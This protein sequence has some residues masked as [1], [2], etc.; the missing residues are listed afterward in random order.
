MKDHPI[1]R[2]PLIL[3]KWF[4]RPS[5]HADIEGDLIQTFNRNVG[6]VGRR[7]AYWKLL[8]DVVR[9]FR[10]GIIRPLKINN[11]KN[12]QPMLRHNILLSFRNFMRYKTSFF[13]NI[14]GL[15][16]GLACVLLIFLWVTDEMAMDQFHKNRER[17]YQV[18]ENVQQSGGVITRQTTSGPTAALVT[19][20]IPEVESAIM[21]TA[22]WGM[23]N[24]ISIDE[25]DI[26][27]TCLY[28][29]E[30]FFRMFSFPLLTGKPGEVLRDKSS[31]V[32]SDWVAINLF[33]SIEGAVGKTVTFDHKKELQVSGVV[34][35]PSNSSL[36]FDYVINFEAFRDE[37]DWVNSWGSTAPRTY[38][39]IKPGSDPAIVGEK[40]ADVVRAK[41]GTQVTHRAQFLRKFT[42]AYLHDRYENGKLVG[43]RVEY[44][45]LFSIIAVFILVIACMNFMNL[46]T[47]RASRRVKEV[48]IKK[49]IGARQWSL[50]GQFLS[51]SILLSLMSLAI[52]TVIVVL[53]L[54]QF[55]LLTGKNLTLDLSS[56][57][58]WFLPIV[59]LATGVLAGSYP[60]WYLSAFR[61]ALV[62]KGKLAGS[63]GE[64]FARK[65]LVAFQFTASII[66]IVCVVVVYKQIEFVQTKDIGYKK[67]NVLMFDREGALW[68]KEKVF[69][70]ELKKLPGIVAAAQTGHDMTGHNGGTS[71]V[72]WPGKDPENRTE[73]ERIHCS[74]GLIELLGLTIAEGRSFTDN[75][76]AEKKN[77]V[78][79]EAAIKFMGITDPIGKQVGFGDETRTIIGVVRDFNFESL[80]EPVKP[81][82]INYKPEWAGMFML[83][84]E[85][86]K[87]QETVA[88]IESLY[89]SFNPGYPF[90]FRF[91]DDDYQTMYVAESR[92]ARLSR[93]FAGLAIVIS[94]LGLFG[95][96][97]FTA[98]RR[99][100]EISIR[101]VLGAG[102][103]R[104]VLLLSEEFSKIMII[105]LALAIPIS[106]FI[107]DRWLQG[108]TFRIELEWWFFAVPGVAALLIAWLS[109]SYQTIKA[110]RVNP[111]ENLKTE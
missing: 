67:D 72:T 7:Q 37:N 79:N 55:N 28:A 65:G 61:P 62:L 102:S 39:L 89:H 97:A 12:Y 82:F 42:D 13:I 70:D 8:G 88:A 69:I 110:A 99:M 50:V 3:F 20:E 27:G 40:I 36:S 80:H 47:A 77:I 66:L 85:G 100:R 98:E 33:G 91:L 52:A 60:A 94:C 19:A 76:E 41:G 75:E 56:H 24:V 38:V 106:W 43:G 4:C 30:P 109:V 86:G 9:L 74:Y 58:L 25:K 17:L 46:S 14:A 71:E 93:Y 32:L 87:E 10:P 104:I 83:R 16:T 84:I 44:V 68:G 107:A 34:H 90:T 1:P 11:P 18:L 29:D 64:T 22:G 81:V 23:Q 6:A 26:K 59:A 2:L 108:F 73:F 45:R 53:L 101:K 92:V 103:A 95:L 51:E 31:I 21:S 48:G 105:A 49:A 15:S 5:Y 54:P 35:V 78:F 96:A 57:T 63:F 111:V